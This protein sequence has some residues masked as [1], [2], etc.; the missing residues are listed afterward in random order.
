MI[1][2]AYMYLS[3]VFEDISSSG[4]LTIYCLIGIFGYFHCVTNLGT[5]IYGNINEN[6]TINEFL[7][8]ERSHLFLDAQVDPKL[9]QSGEHAV[10]KL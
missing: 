10:C 4:L 5:W 6:Q 8:V 3:N 9:I 1:W 2:A 7:H